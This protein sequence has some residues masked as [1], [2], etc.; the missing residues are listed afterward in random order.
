VACTSPR[1]A[2][3]AGGAAPKDRLNFLSTLD[4]VPTVI[5]LRDMTAKGG[6]P[7]QGDGSQSPVLC[8][9]QGRSIACQKGAAI[10]A[11]HLSDFEWR[12]IHGCCSRLA[13][14]ARTS[15]GLSVACS[16]GAATCR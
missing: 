1:G 10:L 12:A 9:R 11:D 7:A 5:T 2:G 14:N 8:T 13:G 16:A 6:G 3:A 4:L 15:K